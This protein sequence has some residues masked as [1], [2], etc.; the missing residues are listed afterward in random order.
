MPKIAELWA[1][2]S[3]D[4]DEND[5]GVIGWNSKMGWLPLV[6]ADKARVESLRQL[7]QQTATITGKPVKLV[8]F[9]TRV[10]VEVV[11]P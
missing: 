1:W 7:A 3:T 4:N 6:G 10:E 8:K 5:E 11:A 2:V 9:T